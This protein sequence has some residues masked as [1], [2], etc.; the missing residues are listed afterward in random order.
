MMN[1]G[2]R[3]VVGTSSGSR[4]VSAGDV[5]EE[6]QVLLVVCLNMNSRRGFTARSRP[7][8]WKFFVQVRLEGVGVDLL[9]HRGHDGNGQ[10]E[11][12]PDHDLVAGS[13]LAPMRAPQQ[14][15]HDH[16]PAEGGHA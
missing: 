10:E 12:E 5:D 6:R 13:V 4:A 14:G 15:Q 16:D 8:G 2:I 7:A 9:R 1:G 3:T 11:C